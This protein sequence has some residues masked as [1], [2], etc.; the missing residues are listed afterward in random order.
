MT[1]CVYCQSNSATTR[2]H[3]PPKAIF[4][5]P[6]PS[7]LVVVPA[8]EECNKSFQNDD[9]YF[10]QC[11][12]LAE[13]ARGHP[14]VAKSHGS[15]FHALNRKEA[16]GRLAAFVQNL[17]QV[18][19][20]TP[21]GLYVGDRLAFDVDLERLFRVVGRTVIGLYFKETGRRLPDGY[22]V[23]VHSDETLASLDPCDLEEDTRNV[24]DPLKR[25][26]PKVIG[27][28]VFAYRHW[29]ASEDPGVSVWLLTFF[30]TISF[31][32]MSGPHISP[33]LFPAHGQ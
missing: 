1:S 21:G 18:E 8:C 14:D 23:K 24:I 5:K 7:N 15:V 30:G 16:P 29:I 31:L 17:R 19:A 27:N 10:Q 13:Q 2:D 28:N 32:V 26:T 6:R 9:E 20:H 22:D 25:L 12:V 33:A 11:L 3:I 4:S